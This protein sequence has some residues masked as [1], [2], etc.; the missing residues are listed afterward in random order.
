VTE[1]L[2]R[3]GIIIDDLVVNAAVVG[4]LSKLMDGERSKLTS[5]AL[6]GFA[7]RLEQQEA[8]GWRYL[9]GIST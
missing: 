2:K 9:I 7:W 3:D 5:Q 6:L 4:G 8:D 1:R